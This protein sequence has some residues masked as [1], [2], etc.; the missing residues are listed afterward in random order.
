MLYI[1]F[2]LGVGN[3]DKLDLDEFWKVVDEIVNLGDNLYL[4][5]TNS[6]E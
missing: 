2:E 4:L 5:H 3:G 6:I 1:D